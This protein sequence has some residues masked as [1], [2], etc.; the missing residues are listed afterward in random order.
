M[1]PSSSTGWP[2]TFKM[3]PSVAG[4]TGTEMGAPVFF[5]DTPRD[6]PS[7]VSIAMQRT[8]FS[9]R[10]EATSTVRLSASALMAGVGDLQ[11]RVDLG[12]A[13][14]GELDVD[15]GSEDLRDATSG[16]DGSAHG[17]AARTTR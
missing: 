13:A 1:G 8:V 17:G 9:P 12:Q 4:P 2:V 11:G 16:G 14:R 7:V 3:R 15:D 6:R 10:C 5:T